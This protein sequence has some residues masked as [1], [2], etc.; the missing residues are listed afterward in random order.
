M[1]NAWSVTGGG[2]TMDVTVPAGTTAEVVIPAGNV[3]ESGKPV[4]WAPGVSSVTYDAGKKA[5][6]VVVGSGSY[7]FRGSK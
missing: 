2:L 5:T 6:V 1:S 3:T 4:R 7:R